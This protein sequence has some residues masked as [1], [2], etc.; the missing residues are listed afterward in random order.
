MST[1]IVPELHRLALPER[2]GVEA[3]LGAADQWVADRER[4]E[5]ELAVFRQFLAAAVPGHTC[6][7]CGESFEFTTDSDMTDYAELQ[8]FI[9][10]HS[11][12]VEVAQAVGRGQSMLAQ[13]MTAVTK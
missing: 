8:H 10:Y 7:D 5:H 11:R 9:G 6:P 12:C 2:S 4:L 3:V 1:P 13:A